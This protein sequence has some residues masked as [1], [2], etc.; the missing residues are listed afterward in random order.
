MPKAGGACRI[1]V[2]PDKVKRE[3]RAKHIAGIGPTAIADG[4]APSVT[5]RNVGYHFSNCDRIDRSATVEN[6]GRI[7]ELLNNSG[8]DV[9]EISRV[10]EVGVKEW[11]GLYKDNDGEAHVVDMEGASIKLVPKW[12]DGP[13]WPVVQPAPAPVIKHRPRPKRSKL[14][15]E[16]R[17]AAILP[18]PQIGF[19]RLE[20]GFM[21]P[22]HDERAIDVALQ[23][24]DHVGVDKIINL[25][26]YLDL[27]EASRFVKEP[28]FALTTQP[29]IDYGT[30]L[31]ARQRQIVGPDGEIIYIEGNHDF[32]LKRWILEN[33][34]WAFGL[35][36]GELPA[37]WP[38]L[39][40][41]SLMRFD[42]LGV[43]FVE[44]YPA[45]IHY[46]N[47]NFACVHGERVNSSG[48]T[49]ERVIDDERVSLA[50]GHIHKIE[51]AYKT[52]RTPK[53]P[54]TRR[55]T[56][57]GCLCRTDGAVPGTRNGP[58]HD[59][60]SP[61]RQENWQQAVGVVTYQDGDGPF[62]LEVIPIFEGWALYRD[63]EFTS[64]VEPEWVERRAA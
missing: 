16:W 53:G 61:K 1:C 40:V 38:V 9:E 63:V 14:G 27:G 31:L 12:A 52:V 13:A 11:Q 8:I 6:L 42:E 15:P 23:V 64:S 18:D 60:L 26:D 36:R 46:V 35:R 25:G 55:A 51:D 17:R 57:L 43:E 39:S 33:A 44:G 10:T 59:G 2:L 32:R 41:P 50:F 37:S 24:A 48:S 7:A 62:S 3:V 22:F 49:A 5:A 20:D 21:D 4:L 56:S 28:G 58:R 19:R 34:G 45:G 29:S 54:K 47:D 30:E